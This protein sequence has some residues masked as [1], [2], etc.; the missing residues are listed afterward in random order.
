MKT[1]ISIPDPIFEAAEKVAKRLAISRSEL[2]AKA[3][4]AFIAAHQTDAV[5][6]TLNEVYA[7]ETSQVDPLVA[8]LQSL[9]I[10]HA[11][12]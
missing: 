2:Y 10:H 5:T 7:A 3:V 11:T 8:K 4:H 12:W 9:S 1:A 6:R